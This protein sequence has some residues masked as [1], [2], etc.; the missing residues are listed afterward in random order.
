MKQNQI[1]KKNNLWKWGFIVLFAVNCGFFVLIGSRLLQKPS[2]LTQIKK[3]KRVATTKIGTLVTTKEQ[4]NTAINSY[5]VDYQSSNTQYQT[6]IT[7]SGILFETTYTLLGY[8]TPLSLYLQPYRLET[9]AIQLKITSFTV[10]T[11]SLPESEVL[12]YIKSSVKLPD[13][14]EIIPKKSVININL[15]NIKIKEKLI[16]KA[17]TVDLINDKITFDL[18]KKNN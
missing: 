5:L 13:F 6:Y 8:K 18:Y 16:I 4:L 1:G 9:G 10:G 12:Q 3:T 11:L 2:D 15:Q 17:K 14:V 7:N